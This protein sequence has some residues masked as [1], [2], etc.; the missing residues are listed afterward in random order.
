[1]SCFYNED[2]NCNECCPFYLNRRS[3]RDNYAGMFCIKAYRDIYPEDKQEDKELDSVL[4]E[5]NSLKKYLA[6][7]EAEEKKK[8]EEAEKLRKKTERDRLMREIADMIKNSKKE[9]SHE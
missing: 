8:A 9:D 1:M 2:R 6:N 5:L 3:D 7:K 4:E